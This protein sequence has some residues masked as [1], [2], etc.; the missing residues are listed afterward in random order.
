MYASVAKNL[1]KVM[2]LSLIHIFSKKMGVMALVLAFPISYFIQLLFVQYGTHQYVKIHFTLNCFE[3]ETKD[4]LIK[5]GPVLIGSATIQVNQFID[6]MLLSL[7]HIFISR[8]KAGLL[9]AISQKIP[10]IFEEEGR[11]IIETWYTRCCYRI[12]ADLR[13][14]GG[15][16]SHKAVSYTHL[17]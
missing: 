6:R 7:I 3:N 12:D 17:Q 16:S 14:P 15:I 4:L 2:N 5:L 11:E 10:H 8:I 9:S 1:Y 13:K